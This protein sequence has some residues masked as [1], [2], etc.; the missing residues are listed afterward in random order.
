MIGI[1]PEIVKR[2]PANRVGAL[3]LR[4]GFCVPGDRAGVLRNIPRS[5]AITLAS[6]DVVVC[7]ARFL[8]WRVKGDVGHVY[9]RS[10]RH[11][12][13]LDGTI[14]IFVI[15]RVFVVP[16]AT[17]QVGYFVT[18]KP[19]TVIAWIWLDPIYCRT[20]RGPSHDSRL[21]SRCAANR[22]EREIGGP[23]DSEL[24]VGGVVI[25]V[26]L[27]RIRL[28]PVP[29]MRSHVLRFSK[30]SRARIERCVQISDFDPDPV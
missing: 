28:A 22:C 1:E 13:R 6:Q 14:K 17:A 11:S 10:Q 9:S 23:A 16:R 3:I 12:E 19:D 30:I 4:K 20:R 5:A 24:T 26:A 15:Q 21:H 7:P 8:R 25:H 2:A 18:H 29:F 27:A